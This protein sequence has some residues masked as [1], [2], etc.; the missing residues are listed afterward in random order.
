MQTVVELP[1]F[2]A[3]ARKVLTEQ[4]RFSIINYLAYHLEAG[5]IMKG[6]RGRAGVMEKASER[7]V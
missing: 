5:R 6:T 2:L 3:R 4:E 7:D 1:E